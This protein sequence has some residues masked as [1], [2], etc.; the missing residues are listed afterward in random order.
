MS[1]TVHYQVSLFNII[2][3]QYHPYKRIKPFTPVTIICRKN[4]QAG[5]WQFS[6]CIHGNYLCHITGI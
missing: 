3:D 4:L 2:R 5:E 6:I 1:P